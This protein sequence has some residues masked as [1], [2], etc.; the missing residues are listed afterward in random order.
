ML[1]C[2]TS[3][4]ADRR[5][6]RHCRAPPASEWI[7]RKPN[8]TALAATACPV[9]VANDAQCL[10][11]QFV[12][13]HEVQ[14]PAFPAATPDQT[15]AFTDAAGDVHDERPGKVGGCLG[16][17][18]RRVGDDDAAGG[19]RR[20]VDIVVADRHVRDYLQPRS[21]VHYVCREHI[22]Q[23]THHAFLSPSLLFSSSGES[24]WPSLRST[25]HAASSVARAEERNP[26][27][28]RTLG[29]GISGKCQLSS[30]K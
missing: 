11:V 27:C 9:T 20:D 30:H 7:T 16:Q 2:P 26:A 10:P 28:K 6:S 23:Q 3:P 25:S 24:W 29:L 14:R 13:E 12:A 8:G 19:R 21:G 4:A 17:H 1:R 5:E 22:R 15:I 18:F